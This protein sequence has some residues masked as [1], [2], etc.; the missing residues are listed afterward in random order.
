MSLCPSCALFLPSA[1]NSPPSPARYPLPN[2]LSTSCC[3]VESTRAESLRSQRVEALRALRERFGSDAVERAAFAFSTVGA[4]R[5][6]AERGSRRAMG[7][8]SSGEEGGVDLEQYGDGG[9]QAEPQEIPVSL[10]AKALRPA[11]GPDCDD[12]RN[13]DGT[14]GG[15]GGGGATVL[16][17]AE[18]VNEA[19]SSE[20]GHDFSEMSERERQEFGLGFEAF[21][22]VAER[23]T[24]RQ[25]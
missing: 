16:L 7:E 20:C 24:G 5:G 4:L 8:G 22:A 2:V 23:L 11:Y 19:V 13:E 6:G 17:T 21:R 9:A 18:A 15:E 3:R 12:D 1:D 25:S 10:V 14:A